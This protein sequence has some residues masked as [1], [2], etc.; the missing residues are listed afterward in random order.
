MSS[1]SRR[2]VLGAA[3]ASLA[4]QGASA[5]SRNVPEGLSGYAVNLDTWFKQVPFEQRFV[6]A[7]KLGFTFIEYWTV[8]RGNTGGK[9]ET[10]RKLADDNGLSLTQFA[11]AW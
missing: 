11:P 4:A 8:D 2:L 7:R 6:L 9:A 1:P 10:W 5:K 3:A